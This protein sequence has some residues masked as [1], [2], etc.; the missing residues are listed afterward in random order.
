MACS[1][2]SFVNKAKQYIG[3][4]ESNNSHRVIIDGYNTIRPLPRG[5]R[6]K[7]NDPWCATFVSFVAMKCNALD[8]IPPECSCGRMQVLAKNA[9]IWVEQ[10]NYKP[11]I[12]DIILYDWDDK[13]K[14][15][16]WG[17]PD[18]IGIVSKTSSTSF[19]VIEGNKSNSVSTRTLAYNARYIRGFIC[20]KF[21]KSSGVSMQTSDLSKIAKLVIRGDYGN[22]EERVSRLTSA[23]FDAR[24]VQDRV[25]EILEKK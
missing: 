12:G 1:R 24:A 2:E 4:N 25:N 13:G 22:G 23:G 18:H 5:Y 10:D 14:G 8:I 17:Y 11:S 21:S 7:Y 19:V 15:D 3:C 20:P 16:C 6:V 9:G